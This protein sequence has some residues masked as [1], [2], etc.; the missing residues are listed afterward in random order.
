[1]ASYVFRL[2]VAG[3]GP[4]DRSAKHYLNRFCREQLDD[5][6][7]VEVIDILAQPDQAAVAGILASQIAFSCLPPQAATH[8]MAEPYP[9]CLRDFSFW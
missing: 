2:Y 3:D 8:F 6:C 4:R 7:H 9:M 1:M 5:Q